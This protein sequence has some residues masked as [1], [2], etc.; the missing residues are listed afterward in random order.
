MQSHEVAA[1]LKKRRQKNASAFKPS[2]RVENPPQNQAVQ[3]RGKQHQEPTVAQANATLTRSSVNREANVGIENADDDWRIDDPDD[4]EESAFQTQQVPDMN[5]TIQTRVEI[6]Q[7]QL[8]SQDAQQ[9]RPGIPRLIDEQANAEKLQWESQ[10]SD[11]ISQQSGTPEVSQDGGFQLPHRGHRGAPPQQREHR[12][13]QTSISEGAGRS[14]KRPRTDNGHRDNE[15]DTSPDNQGEDK[16]QADVYNEAKNAARIVTARRPKNPQSRT[17][18]TRE[19]EG[20][21]MDLIKDYGC[22]WTKL[23]TMDR[24]NILESRDQVALKDKARNM[25]VNFLL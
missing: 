6:N 15:R 20:Q 9:Q 22:S 21:L 4:D 8:G 11:A 10:N 23:K 7:A 19:E 18:W 12:R 1:S 2:S 14:S 5:H 16:T 25:K 3:S 17:F 24:E 13:T